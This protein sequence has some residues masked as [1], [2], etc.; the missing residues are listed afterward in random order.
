MLNFQVYCVNRITS[1]NV[2]Y[3]KLLRAGTTFNL[4]AADNTNRMIGRF[5][6]PASWFQA[7]NAIFI[8]VL[9]P[10]FSYLWTRLDAYKLN[11][12]TPYKFGWGMLLLAVGAVV[13]GV[14]NA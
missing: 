11:P 3:T 1:Y 2:C 4:F 5:E 8:V 12:K 14:A 10:V 7:I 9:A 6:V 13:M